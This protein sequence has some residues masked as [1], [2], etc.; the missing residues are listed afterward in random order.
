MQNIYSC[1]YEGYTE[2]NT[3]LSWTKNKYTLECFIL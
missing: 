1:K 3:A 2:I